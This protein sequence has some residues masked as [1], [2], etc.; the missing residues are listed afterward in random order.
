MRATVGDSL[1]VK[2]SDGVHGQGPLVDLRDPRIRSGFGTM[3]V[4]VLA[5]DNLA[6]CRRM[7]H[8]RNYIGHAPGRHEKSRLFAR[9]IGRA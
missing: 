5:D 6:A 4:G 9:Q 2:A 8:H 1:G 3:D 7:N